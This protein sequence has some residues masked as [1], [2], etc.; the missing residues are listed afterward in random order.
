[1]FEEKKA[2]IEQK[3]GELIRKAEL[4]KAPKIKYSNKGAPAGVIASRKQTEN[5]KAG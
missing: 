5:L 3:V 4:G 2:L 1:L